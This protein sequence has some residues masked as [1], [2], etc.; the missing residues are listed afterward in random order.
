[1]IIVRDL[2]AVIFEVINTIV[3]YVRVAGIP[4]LIVIKVVLVIVWVVWTVILCVNVVVPIIIWS[5]I[6]VITGVTNPIFI[7]VILCRI[8]GSRAV[9]NFI[10][11]RITIDVL[12][13]LITNLILIKV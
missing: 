4:Y 12:I 6:A 2:R 13:T 1:M 11:Q 5:V 7:E 9:I 8:Y 10:V 3:I